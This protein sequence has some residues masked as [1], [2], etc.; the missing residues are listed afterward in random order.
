MITLQQVA[1][2]RPRLNDNDHAPRKDRKRA[3]YVI[4]WGSQPP[5][6]TTWQGNLAEDRSLQ[7]D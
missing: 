5:A 1:F 4:Q 6:G 7:A 3:A 2:N